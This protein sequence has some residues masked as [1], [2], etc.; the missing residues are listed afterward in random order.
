[1]VPEKR[2]GRSSAQPSVLVLYNCDYDEEL[3]RE[4]GVDVSAVRQSA[5]GVRDALI[6]YGFASEL[7]GVQGADLVGVAVEVKARQ[8]D[9]V[10]NLCESLAGDVQ[11][12][13]IVPAVLELLGLP[14]TGA[15]P[16]TLGLCLHKPRA[17]EV[18]AAHG[19]PSPAYRVVRTVAE[20]ERCDVPFPVFAKLAHEDASIGIDETNLCHDRAA[21]AG[22]VRELVPVYRQPL[23]VERYVEGREVNVSL[24][25]NESDLRV[26]P[27]H[28]IDFSAMP[29]GRPRIVSYAA[30]WDPDHVDYEGTKPVP[31]KPMAE[32]TVR[33]IEAAAIGAHRALEL[34]DFCRVDL[35]VDGEGRAW[36]IDVNPNCDLSV[37]AGFARAARSA[38]LGY[39]ELC[40]RICEIAWRRHD[41]AHTAPGGD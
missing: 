11:N 31:M 17:K 30:K 21:L 8:P 4:E 7:I 1:L 3:T 13:P 25:G 23:L 32:A 39:P 12:E 22:R 9:L 34:R 15:G 14:Y 36:V 41:R 29:V 33:T 16:L 28:E 19:V 26:L 18:L 24:L 37:D 27:L 2:S 5:L 10:F 6:E 35:R 20:A 40:G 38:G